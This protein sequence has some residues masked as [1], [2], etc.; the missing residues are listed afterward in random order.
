M[1]V[2][3]TWSSPEAYETMM[4]HEEAVR[5][6]DEHVAANKAARQA[7]AGLRQAM[8]ETQRELAEAHDQIA[9][10]H[11]KIAVAHHQ[12]A[13]AHHQIAAAQ[14]EVSESLHAAQR[15][16][17]RRLGRGLAEAERETLA[18]RF[19]R[20]GPLRVL[21]VVLDLDAPALAAWLADPDAR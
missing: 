4:S 2:S 15:Q 17:E 6:W 11:D 1:G 20:L 12:I 8:V 21:D 16:F 18:A 10:A 9:A 3:V 7:A 13:T 5:I 19:H 14:R